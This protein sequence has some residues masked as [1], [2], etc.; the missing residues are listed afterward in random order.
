MAIDK[1]ENKGTMKIYDAFK[2]PDCVPIQ[3]W[4]AL[5]VEEKKKVLN[6][7]RFSGFKPGSYQGVTFAGPFLP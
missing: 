6:S 5:T 2:W 7:Y 3:P 4:E 1:P